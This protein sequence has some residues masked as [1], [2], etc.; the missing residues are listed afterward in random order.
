MSLLI[1]LLNNGAVSIFGIILSASFCNSFNTRRERVITLCSMTVILLLQGV[2]YSVWNAD[3]LRRI[4][5]L[6]I[7]LPL[8]LVLYFV[9]KKLLW[10]FISVFLS[11][12]CCQ[13][14]RW[15]ALL[16]V[17]LASGGPMMQD[18]AETII[19]L[20]LLLILLRFVAPA[21]RRSAGR[22]IKPQLHFGMI[23][24]IYYAFDYVTSVYTDLL[25]GGY[26][27]V[28]EFMP[29]VCC[30]AYL[31][32]L[33]YNSAEEQKHSQLLQVQK[34]LDLQLS[35]SVRE[36]NALRESQALAS[37]YRHD[38]RHHLQYVLS[39]IK[40]GQEEQAQEYISGICH[41]IEAQ[42]VHQYCENEA[43]NLIISAF[44]KRAK[45]A[46]IN[47][48]VQGSLSSSNIISDSDLC[49]LLSNALENAVNAC[50]PFAAEGKACVI[51][52]RFYERDNKLFLQLT[53]PCGEGIRFENDIPVSDHPN[54]G[55][56]VQSIC[57]I[58]KRYGG[59]YAFLVQDGRF[60]LR[61][62]L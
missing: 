20:P 37:Q 54:H 49:V 48:N 29:F 13:L 22:S 12:L 18:I 16:I 60:I 2:L 5:P 8:V 23:P 45:S 50:R 43:A 9:S 14:R 11:Y 39:C 44:A 36:I 15:L 55:I 7:H 32:F 56:G 21:V 51:D 10:S 35:Q 62:S 17:T 1:F 24:A 47:M 27:V 59:I 52:L 40:N 38:M 4:Y 42:K 25:S 26:P 33:L 34:S 30:A 57:A 31:V 28:V 46:N 61:L 19:T 3:I 6:V 58:V 53:N 41:E